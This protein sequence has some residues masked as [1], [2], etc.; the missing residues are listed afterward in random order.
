MRSG[1]SPFLLSV[2]MLGQ[3]G[4]SVDPEEE[5]GGAGLFV[6]LLFAMVISVKKD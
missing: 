5:S 1:A 6:S 4:V 2:L 3:L